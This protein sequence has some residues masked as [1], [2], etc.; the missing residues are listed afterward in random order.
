MTNL[1]DSPDA[2]NRQATDGLPALAALLVRLTDAD[3]TVRM[4]AAIDLRYVGDPRAIPALLEVA[5][6]AEPDDASLEARDTLA[7]LIPADDIA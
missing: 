5:G 4:W 2:V 7:A 6:N 1:P 3:P